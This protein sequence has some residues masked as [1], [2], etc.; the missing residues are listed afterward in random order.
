MDNGDGAD[1]LCVSRFP[2]PFESFFC[3]SF[4]DDCPC[5]GRVR[6]E[7]LWSRGFR[8]MSVRFCVSPSRCKQNVRPT[9]PLSQTVIVKGYP[10]DIAIAGSADF[11]S[12]SS[13]KSNLFL[14]FTCSRSVICWSL[15][16]WAWQ[17]TTLTL[18]YNRGVEMYVE[19]SSH[20]LCLI[21]KI[22]GSTVALHWCLATKSG[23][24]L[25]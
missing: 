20:L 11:N 24:R 14:C 9:C 25:N 4:R 13:V 17:W 15:S 18:F 23:H 7:V 16:L 22:L 19:D 6:N 10:C 21:S 3:I 2:D 5:A 12:Q 8:Y 1:L